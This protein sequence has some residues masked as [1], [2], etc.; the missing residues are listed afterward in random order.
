[1]A[2]VGF[3]LPLTFMDLENQGVKQRFGSQ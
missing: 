2:T 1:M 3:Q